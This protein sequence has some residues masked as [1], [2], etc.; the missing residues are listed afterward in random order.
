MVKA[1]MITVDA[2][3]EMAVSTVYQGANTRLRLSHIW[4]GFYLRPFNDEETTDEWAPE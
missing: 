1:S 3:K 2:R 4:D